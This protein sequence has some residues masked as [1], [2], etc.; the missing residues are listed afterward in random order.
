MNGVTVE[1][2]IAVVKYQLTVISLD[3]GVLGVKCD[4]DVK[5]NAV[6]AIVYDR[7]E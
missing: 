6:E 3:V 2:N 5:I 1:V 7:S 4:V